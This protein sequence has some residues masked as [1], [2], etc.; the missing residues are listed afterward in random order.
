MEATELSTPVPFDFSGDRIL[1]VPRIGENLDV[2]EEELA[3][4]PDRASRDAWKVRFHLA[5]AYAWIGD[6]DKAFEHL[7]PPSQYISYTDR[8]D[9]LN[10][11]WEKITDDPRWLEYREAIG[12]SPE[13]LDAIEFDPWLP[14]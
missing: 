3:Q 12:M 13:R 14:E 2:D 6:A 9:V 11:V 10:P 4:Q 7:M 5:S 1:T 8:L